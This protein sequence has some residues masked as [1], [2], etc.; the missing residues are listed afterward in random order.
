M[1]QDF[2]REK[3]DSDRAEWELKSNPGRREGL[4]TGTKVG[5]MMGR[6]RDR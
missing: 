6:S 3:L 1:G 5:R 4:A 2:R